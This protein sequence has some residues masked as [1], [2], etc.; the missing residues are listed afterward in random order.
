MGPRHES[1]AIPAYVV[2]TR[3]SPVEGAKATA[4]LRAYFDSEG[5]QVFDSQIPQRAAW[6]ATG[7][8]GRAVHELKGRDRSKKAI[9]EM[10]A[11]YREIIVRINGGEDE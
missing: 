8:T 2:L 7:K 9:D 6:L 5:I 11:V 4:D 3:V 1:G 10:D